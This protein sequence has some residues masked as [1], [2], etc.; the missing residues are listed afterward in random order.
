[1]VYSLRKLYLVGIFFTLIITLTVP[2]YADKISGLSDSSGKPPRVFLFEQPHEALKTWV[3]DGEKDRVLII[4]SADL[5]LGRMDPNDLLGSRDLASANKWD[6]LL[7]RDFPTV[8]KYPINARNYLYFAHEAGIIKEIYWVPPTK[9]S[10][11]AMSLDDYKNT[12]ES[13]GALKSDLDSLKQDGVSI[14]GTIGGVPVMIYSLKDLPALGEDALVVFDVSF[15]ADL[16]ENEVK[17]PILDMFSGVFST[18]ESKHI[19]V[20]EA[21]VSYSTVLGSAPLELRYVGDYIF[22]Y[23]KKPASVSNRPPKAW[24]L[25][26]TALYYQSF[27]QTDQGIELYRQAIKLAPKDASL[28]YDLARTYFSSK[29][30]GLAITELNRAVS[31]DRHYYIAYITYGNDFLSRRQFA[32][33]ESLFKAAV[34]ANPK[35]PRCWDALRAYCL[36]TRDIKCETRVVNRF[37]AL[38]YDNATDYAAYADDFQHLG[39]HN[40]AIELFQKALSKVAAPDA[41]TSNDILLGLAYSY[42]QTRRFDMAVDCYERALATTNDPHLKG[43]ITERMDALKNPAGPVLN[44]GRLF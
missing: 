28:R 5:S 34:K 21:V 42:E 31:L 29:D 20:S 6:Q 22:T 23:L 1:M 30:N 10:V 11:G 41:A 36:E 33:A 3:K 27:Y 9:S 37:I 18:I 44:P 19:P 7:A 32:V 24:G 17:T 35:D 43:Q 26:S 4:F 25:H 13:Q 14:K 2:A 16:Y 12:L 40:K 8:A 38:G 39:R 15:F